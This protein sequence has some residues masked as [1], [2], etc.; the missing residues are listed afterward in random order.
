MYPIYIPS[1]G[2]WDNC[3]TAN[4]LLKENIPFYI[5]V[6]P[7]EKKQY[8]E[9]Y[10]VNKILVLPFKNVS[11]PS[12]V[13]TWIKHHS[14][15]AGDKRHWQLDDNINGFYK[16]VKNKRVPSD[17]LT[18]I[19][20]CETFIDE[21]KNVAIAGLKNKAY[22]YQ[23]KESYKKNQQVYCCVLV[24]N[25]TDLFWRT[26]TPCEDTDYSLQALASGWCTVLIQIYQIDKIKT[27]G[28][29]GGNST[30]YDN[31]G[32]VKRV[33]ELQRLWGDNII[34]LSRRYGRPQQSLGHVWRKYTTPLE[35]I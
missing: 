11:S 32:R 15:M 34:K 25:D 31:D 29:K 1:K 18:T 14:T 10:G 21:F 4:V 23:I 20:E 17:A 8:E 26:K 22:G 6:E 30:H 7:Q 19:T 24:L 16:F 33:R 3:I 5:V 27:G 2:R 35:R 13:R 12:P 9:Q 28:M